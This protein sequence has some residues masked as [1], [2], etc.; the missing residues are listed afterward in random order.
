[1]KSKFNIIVSA[2]IVGA[3][4]SLSSCTEESAGISK[5]TTFPVITLKGN[6]SIG[7]AKGQPYVDPGFTALEGTND[8]SSKVVVK[9][10]VDVNVSGPYKLVYEA[11]NSD[12]FKRSVERTVIVYDKSSISSV[13]ISGNYSSRITRKV[14][15]TGVTANRGPFTI[16]V[17][18]LADGLFQIDDLLGGWYYYGSNYGVGYA[19]LGYIVLK[20]DN[21]ISIAYSTIPSWSDSVKFYATSTYDPATGKIFLNSMMNA[22]TN[23]EFAVTL[24]K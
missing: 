16:V 6:A 13:D 20:A 10:S 17:T 14:L 22:A 4:M 19:G 15:S 23:Y 7:V 2:L 1:M 9:G 18:K 5:V 12:G 24:S 3:V 21:T 8:I 11:T